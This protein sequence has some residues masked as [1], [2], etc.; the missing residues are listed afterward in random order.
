MVWFK[1]HIQ[2]VFL[3]SRKICHISS[4]WSAG[5]LWSQRTLE[6][7]IFLRLRWLRH[8][9]RPIEVWR[10]FRRFLQVWVS[11]LLVPP[12]RGTNSLNN[13]RPNSFCTHKWRCSTVLF[14]LW[15]KVACN[16]YTFFLSLKQRTA[17]KAVEG[18][19]QYIKMHVCSRSFSQ[20]VEEQVIWLQNNVWSNL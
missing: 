19:L 20:N 15:Y 10:T 18:A 6:V 11:L 1:E 14:D 5:R 12:G 17:A 16:P 2:Y 3:I 8:K 9:Y 13:C 4:H 7:T